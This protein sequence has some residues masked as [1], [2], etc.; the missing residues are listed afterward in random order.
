MTAAIDATL[1]SNPGTALG[2]PQIVIKSGTT[3]TGATDYMTL[4]LANFGMTN[5]LAWH[6]D[7]HTTDYSVIVH[8]TGTTAVSAGVFTY[9]TATGNNNKRRILIVWGE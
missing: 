6:C 5:V 2:I 3:L 9:T 7:V 8:E 1:V 4:T